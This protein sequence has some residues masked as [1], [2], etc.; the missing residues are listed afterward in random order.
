MRTLIYKR[1]HTGDPDRSGRF[2]I[3]DCMG[4]VRRWE[5]D[6]VIGVAGFGRDATTQR[7]AG[8]VTWIGIGPHKFPAGSRRGPLVTFDHFLLLDAKGPS[9]VA[10]APHL[11]ARFYSKNIRVMFSTVNEREAREVS[12]LLGLARDAAPSSKRTPRNA[13]PHPC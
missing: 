2:G 5:F 1:T 9:F 10:R 11:A 13:R 8:K 3:Y 4:S 7:I 6:A 12:R